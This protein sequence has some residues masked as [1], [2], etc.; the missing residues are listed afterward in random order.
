MIS[1]FHYPIQLTKIGLLVSCLLFAPLLYSTP[2]PKENGEKFAIFVVGPGRCGSSCLM[3]VLEILGVPIG[4]NFI[5]YPMNAKG[6]FEDGTIKTINYKITKELVSNGAIDSRMC[7]FYLPIIN[8]LK[9]PKEK[10]KKT[11]KQALAKTFGKF[12]SFAL[13]NPRIS[14]LL[15]LYLTAAQEL[16]FTPKIIVMLREPQEIISSFKKMIPQK[17][18][19]TFKSYLNRCLMSILKD[20]NGYDLLSIDFDTLLNETENTINLLQDFIPG[21]KN[22]QEVIDQLEVFLDR[23]L[24]HHNLK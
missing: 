21:L 17:H 24:K 13:K 9:Q 6:E 2:E 20:S 11:V 23:D 1:N 5:S 8:W 3:G 22:Y 4:K 12:N 19:G 10:Y 18:H 7:M 16:G 15:P 14:F